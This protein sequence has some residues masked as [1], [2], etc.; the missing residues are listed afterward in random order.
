MCENRSVAFEVSDTTVL[1]NVLKKIGLQDKREK[2]PEANVLKEKQVRPKTWARERVTCPEEG[3]E[4]R[5][6]SGQIP[7]PLRG[8][9]NV[10]KGVS[11]VLGPGVSHPR[12]AR[13]RGPHPTR[14]ATGSL[15]AQGQKW[16]QCNTFGSLL[17]SSEYPNPPCAHPT[18]AHSF[19]LGRPVNFSDHRSIIVASNSDGIAATARAALAVRSRSGSSPFLGF[20][21]RAGAIGLTKLLAPHFRRKSAISIDGQ[22]SPRHLFAGPNPL[23]PKQSNVPEPARWICVPNPITPAATEGTNP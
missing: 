16:Q 15:A 6:S 18:S 2:C 22:V 11:I 5:P 20:P 14:G 13:K 4:A 19:Q 8:G 23:K 10:L 17:G 9:G 12:S 21:E 3:P 7:R 1:K